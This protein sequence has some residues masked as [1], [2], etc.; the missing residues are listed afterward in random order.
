M[1]I[2]NLLLNEHVMVSPINNALITVLVANSLPILF[3]D[4][5]SVVISHTNPVMFKNQINEVYGILKDWFN[6][7]LLSLNTA[8]NMLHKLYS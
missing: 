5:T 7:N 6:K 4:D 3:A 2:I 8:K 1:N